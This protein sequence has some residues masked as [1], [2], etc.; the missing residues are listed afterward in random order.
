VGVA[1]ALIYFFQEKLV[2]GGAGLGARRGSAAHAVR[3]TACGRARRGPRRPDAT[4]ALPAPAGAPC[5]PASSVG[6]AHCIRPPPQLYVPR[7]PG[8]PDFDER[9]VPERYGFEAEVRR[10]F[11]GGGRCR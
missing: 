2:S 9:L 7:L 6:R 8:V 1:V 4:A 10:F 5:A 3:R 11:G